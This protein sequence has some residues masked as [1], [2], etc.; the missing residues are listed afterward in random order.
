V[1]AAAFDAGGR[2]L[3]SARGPAF[4]ASTGG[5]YALSAR[6]GA[7]AATIAAAAPLFSFRWTSTTALCIVE[8]IAVTVV[9]VTNITTSLTAAIEAVVAR[10][11][12]GSDSSG[13]AITLSGNNAKKRTD[14]ATSVVGDARIANTSA[15]T[16][17]TRTL[18]STA[19]GSVDYVTGTVGPNNVLVKTAL[20]SYE[21]SF[22]PIVLEADEG[23]VI[24]N[25]L[26]G[27]ADGTWRLAV[28]VAWVE[29]A[30]YVP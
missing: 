29:T 2:A 26:T 14:Y 12:T 10:A 23:F 28:D 17:G 24:R 20:Y 3:A 6:T 18:D 25:V 15:L 1:S 8:R 19:I 16:A 11:F 22:D 7:L 13:T 27:P 5:A 9:I 21:N 4:A 30:A